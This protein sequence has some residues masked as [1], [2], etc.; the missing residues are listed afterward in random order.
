MTSAEAFAMMQD[1][2]DREGDVFAGAADVNENH[3]IHYGNPNDPV[4]DEGPEEYVPMYDR[5]LNGVEKE[6]WDIMVAEEMAKMEL[7]FKGQVDEDMQQQEIHKKDGRYGI[8]QQTGEQRLDIPPPASSNA[9]LPKFGARGVPQQDNQSILEQMEYERAHPTIIAATRPPP[10]VSAP[11][12]RVR[13]PQEQ[14]ATVLSGIGSTQLSAEQRKTKQR[15]LYEQAEVDRRQKEAYERQAAVGD[16]DYDPLGGGAVA[17]GPSPQKQVSVDRSYRVQPEQAGDNYSGSMDRL[18]ATAASRGAPDLKRLK[19]EEY[20]AQLRKDHEQQQALKQADTGRT[21]Q[22]HPPASPAPSARGH[23]SSEAETMDQKRMQQQRYREQLQGQSSANARE[24]AAK[25]AEVQER[26]LQQARERDLQMLQAEENAERAALEAQHAERRRQEGERMHAVRMAAEEQQRE[27]DEAMKKLQRQRQQQEA[28]E[29]AEMGRVA[30][31]TSALRLPMAETSELLRKRQQQ[32]KYRELMERDMETARSLG[33][34]AGP[35][36]DPNNAYKQPGGDREKVREMQQDTAAKSSTDVFNGMGSYQSGKED[37]DGRKRAQEAYVRALETDRQQTMPV[38]ER[39]GLRH[40]RDEPDIHVN[41]NIMS[42]N[43][44]PI[45]RSGKAASIAEPGGG[46]AQAV[47]IGGQE[48]A[49]EK[50][51]ERKYKQTLYAQQLQDDALQKTIFSPRKAYVRNVEPEEDRFGNRGNNSGRSIGRRDNEADGYWPENQAGAGGL[52]ANGLQSTG[53]KTRQTMK[54]ASQ[55]DHQEQLA[56]D[57]EDRQRAKAMEAQRTQI[58]N[59]R[60][61]RNIGRPSSE[62]GGRNGG[63]IGVDRAAPSPSP[64]TRVPMHQYSP[65][66]PERTGFPVESQNITTAARHEES[67]RRRNDYVQQLQ[68]DKESPRIEESRFPLHEIKKREH[69]VGGYSGHRVAEMEGQEH[70]RNE[71]SM[72]IGVATPELMQREKAKLDAY[73]E[74][75]LRDAEAKPIIAQRRVSPRRPDPAVQRAAEQ[76]EQLRKLEATG[77]SLTAPERELLDMY[78]MSLQLES[79]ETERYHEYSQYNRQNSELNSGFDASAYGSERLTNAQQLGREEASDARAVKREQQQRYAESV[80]QAR[81]LPA[82]EQSRV[83]LLQLR[84]EQEENHRASLPGASSILGRAGSAGA[85]GGKPQLSARE[86]QIQRA[87]EHAKSLALEHA[88]RGNSH[89]NGKSTSQ[90]FQQSRP[91]WGRSV[92]GGVTSFSISGAPPSYAPAAAMGFSQDERKKEYSELSPRSQGIA[93]KGNTAAMKE[94]LY[95]NPL[96]Y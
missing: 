20:Q 62:V 43:S 83:P 26:R 44:A 3:G 12:G 29:A 57:A 86:Y 2:D 92:G 15:M 80:E 41:L 51:L 42:Q 23:A 63:V 34:R 90:Q 76:A 50:A 22:A 64:Q 5:Q 59:H 87:N 37:K 55:S 16:E 74:A 25:A 93:R 68:A 53:P 48:Q 95:N 7:E 70:G 28:R 69:F 40:A 31:G 6:A 14:P 9:N 17:V 66:Q 52:F 82:I 21:L 19:Q 67:S 96:G 47:F 61:A 46:A 78:N 71:T 73:N 89:D 10:K 30:P 39:V 13:T 75:R 88:G 56:R 91:N 27:D 81:N 45:P 85:E 72:R 8:Y 54:K 33:S 79:M 36:Y 77:A 58:E 49:D 4:D 65:S 84:Q 18:A 94:R 1:D 32:E 35:Q 11:I 60:S 24:K 38:L